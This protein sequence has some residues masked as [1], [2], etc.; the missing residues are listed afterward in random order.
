MGGYIGLIYI[1]IYIQGLCRGYIAG[2]WVNGSLTKTWRIKST[3]VENDMEAG[4]T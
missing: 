3:T 2:S 4:D 1:Y